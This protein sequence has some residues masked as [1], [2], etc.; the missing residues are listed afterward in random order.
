MAEMKKQN[1]YGLTYTVLAEPY[2]SSELA[3]L[4]NPQSFGNTDVVSIQPCLTPTERSQDR[5]VVEDWELLDGTHWKFQA[6]CDGHA[7]HETVDHVVATLPA[8]VQNALVARLAA[9]P[10]EPPEV[11]LILRNA[12][13]EVDDQ[14]SSEFLHLFPSGPDAI[15]N[16]SD[17]E[18][19]AIINDGGTSSAK[20]LRCMRGSTV[21]VALISPGLD[22]WVASLGDCQAG[23][24]F[25]LRRCPFM[26]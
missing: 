23:I 13:A 6:V 1:V 19:A 3:R 17:D 11:S 15:A 2:L 12:I 4:A 16:L 14:I 25:V 10:L 20:V 9:G 21:L 26:N 5:F 18:I 24:V 7:G 8:A 22:V